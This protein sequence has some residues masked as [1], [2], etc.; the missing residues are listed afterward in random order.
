M[1]AGSGFSKRLM[2]KSS[3]MDLYKYICSSILLNYNSEILIPHN[4]YSTVIE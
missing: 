3:N 2:K 4:K 1:G